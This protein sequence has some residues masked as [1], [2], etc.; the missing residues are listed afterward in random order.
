MKL[1]DE[2]AKHIH[3]VISERMNTMEETFA[4][5]IRVLRFPLGDRATVNKAS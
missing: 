5:G 4:D 1:S 2:R 3:T